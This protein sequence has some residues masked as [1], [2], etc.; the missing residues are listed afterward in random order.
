MKTRHIKTCIINTFKAFENLK[1]T[2]KN[3]YEDT[4][5]CTIHVNTRFNTLYIDIRHK[6]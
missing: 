5:Q 1:K 3:V 4:L 6:C 2:N